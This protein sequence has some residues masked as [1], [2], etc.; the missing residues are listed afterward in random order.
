MAEVVFTTIWRWRC[1]EGCQQVG[2][3][4]EEHVAMRQLTNHLLGHHA[5]FILEGEV[6]EKIMVC[7]TTSPRRRD[8]LLPGS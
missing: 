2:L 8:L 1:P 5:G 6:A 3:A 7:S 4:I